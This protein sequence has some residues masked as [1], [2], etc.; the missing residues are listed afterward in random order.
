MADREESSRPLPTV[1]VGGFYAEASMAPLEGIGVALILR[2]VGADDT[3]HRLCLTKTFQGRLSLSTT[4]GRGD[5]CD[6]TPT[7]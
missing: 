3:T 4:L 1:E 2:P 5:S 7:A 6:Q